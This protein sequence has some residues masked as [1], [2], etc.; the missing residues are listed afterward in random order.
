MIWPSPQVKKKTI[1]TSTNLPPCPLSALDQF[2]A[3]DD[4]SADIQADGDTTEITLNMAGILSKASK[5]RPS[6]HK[7][8][9]CHATTEK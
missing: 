5:G 7:N 2:Q 3:L 8:M 4:A 6:S 9:R 1:S